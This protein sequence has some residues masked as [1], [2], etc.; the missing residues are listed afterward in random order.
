MKRTHL[1]WTTVAAVAALAI[2]GVGLAAAGGDGVRHV[3]QGQSIQ[4]AVDSARP[5]DTI[6]VDAGVYRENVSIRKDGITL[7]GAGSGQ[8]GTVL[9]PPAAP[10]PSDCNES[11]EVVGICIA[12]VF[13]QGSD[14]VGRPVQDTRVS[15]IRVRG[16]SRFGIVA[17]NAVDTT[18]ER[19][20]VSGS[21]HFG[22]AA[23]TVR[24]VRLLDNRSHDNGQ[25]GF[26]IADGNDMDAVV[27]GNVASGNTSAE[28]LGMF[29]RDASHGVVADNRVEGN[30]GGI[31][32]VDSAGDG[33]ATGWAVRGNVVR[34]NDAACS[35]TDEVP[36]PLSGFGIAL[37][38]TSLT[39]VEANRVVGNTP[40]GDTAA[41]GGIVLAS[42]KVGG[43]P[44]PHGTF[45]TGNVLAENGPA[46]LVTDGS[47]T[48]NRLAGNRCRTSLPGGLCR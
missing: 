41:A 48:A 26:Y 14:E 18:I 24:G 30:C 39:H 28:G 6:V 36:V 40:T 27:T 22:I 7:R 21:G 23:I 37:L 16:F 8:D 35:A 10:H 11:G 47:G 33:P 45:V 9:E 4:A 29:I 15:D 13:V 20:D 31:L 43:G 38:G 44:D 17:Y 32:V 5:G 42:A 25:S 46:D 12:G 2:A 3:H 1:I 34:S 19:T